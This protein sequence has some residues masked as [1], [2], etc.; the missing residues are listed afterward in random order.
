MSKEIIVP[1]SP[2]RLPCFIGGLRPA[3]FSR[4]RKVQQVEVLYRAK[5]LEVVLII[6]GP[7]T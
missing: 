7:K 6:I 2:R 4:P 3:N 5:E 1:D